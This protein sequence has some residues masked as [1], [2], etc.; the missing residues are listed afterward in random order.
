MPFIKKPT[1]DQE[2][3]A[4]LRRMAETGAQDRQQGRAYL[5]ES[6]LAEVAALTTA[7]AVALEQINETLAARIKETRE[8]RAAL[9]RLTIYVRD[10]WQG[11]VRRM[12]R[13]NHSAEVL[14]LH[15]L[16]TEGQSPHPTR[17]EEWI[18]WAERLVAGDALAVSAGLPPM[19]N[20]TSVEVQTVLEQARAEAANVA[21]AD[22]AYDEA[23][24]ALSALRGQADDLIDLV[25]AHLRL[26]LR[27][28]DPSSQRR[29][30]RTYGVVYATRQ[31]EALPEEGE[32]PA[33]DVPAPDTTTPDDE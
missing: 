18:L 32:S 16:S 14:R 10:Y 26:A 20:P 9:E 5:P 7:L 8:R 28:F 31:G 6:L 19:C 33:P 25:V 2:R 23:Q 29:I 13:E 27:S 21:E 4:W 30:M 15:G 24:A 12:R 1:A 22:R 17:G 3:L 11:L